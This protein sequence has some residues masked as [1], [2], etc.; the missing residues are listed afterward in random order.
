[1]VFRTLQIADS[2][3]ANSV[4]VESRFILLLVGLASFCLLFLAFFFGQFAVFGL[5]RYF[6]CT[7]FLGVYSLGSSVGFRF[8]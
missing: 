8:I 5:G 2:A 1:M 3:E 6:V 4:N 7:G